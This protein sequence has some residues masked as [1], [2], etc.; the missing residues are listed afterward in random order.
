MDDDLDAILHGEEPEVQ[1]RDEQGRFAPQGTGETPLEPETVVAEPVEP[2]EQPLDREEFE[3]L[4]N[5]RKR[6]QDAERE[7]DEFRQRLEALERQPKEPPAPP[8][9]VF[10]DEAGYGEHVAGQAVQRATLNARL[11][12]SEMLAR[13]DHEDFDAMKAEFLKMADENPALVQQAIGDPDPWRKAYT[14]AK[15]AATMRE[16]GAVDMA[17]LETKMRE[18]IMAEIEAQKPAIPA[19]PASLAD[20]QSARGADIHTQNVPLTLEEILGR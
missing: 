14:I 1:A 7:R 19:L 18:K 16:M 11:D 3:G 13:R 9:S 8:P 5:E 6:R 4:K 20:V 15:N 17:S 10:E 2:T 12:M